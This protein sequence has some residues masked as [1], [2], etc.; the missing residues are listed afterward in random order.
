MSPLKL[1]HAAE[2]ARRT[3]G[4]AK[5]PYFWRAL[6]QLADD[7]GFKR[8]VQEALPSFS[9]FGQMDRRR[10]LQLLGASLAFGGL[11]A[12]SGPPPEQIVPWVMQPPDATPD[13]PKF[14]A[15]TLAYAGD[16]IGVLVES[17][18][19]RPTKIEGNPLHPDS[20]GATGPLPQAAVLEVWDPDRSQTP[21]HRGAKSTWEAFTAEVTAWPASYAHDAS[22]LHVLSDRIVSPT[23]RAQR[24]RWLARFPGSRWHEYAPVSQDNAD[25]GAAL[26]FGKMV[27]PRYHFDQADVI[28][29]LEAEFLDVMPGRVAYARAFAER[30]KAEHAAQTMN[31]LYVVEATPSL[32]GTMADHRWML[33]SSSVALFALELAHALDIDPGTTPAAPSGITAKRLQALRSDLLAHRGRS[34]ILAGESQ[35]PEVHALVH[36]LNEK[37]GNTGHTVDYLTLPDDAGKRYSIE[38]L[39][40]AIR[41]G[42]VQQLVVLDCNAAYAAPADLNF[43][44]LL[45]RVPKLVHWGLYVDETAHLADW[46]VPASHAL[47]SWSD[48]QTRAGV[49]SIVQPLIEPLYGGRS[50]H[51]FLALL[52][53]EEVQDG[54][55]IV[56]G[57]WRTQHPSV[58]WPDSVRAGLVS[59]IA[60]SIADVRVRQG[61]LSG[62]SPALPSAAVLELIFRPDATVW[63]GRYANNGWLQELSKW[64]SQLTWSNAAFVSPQLAREQDLSHGDVVLLRSH[65]R[66]V[67]APVWITPGQAPRSVTIHLGYGRKR[68]GRVGDNLGFNAYLLR[69]S[70]QPWRAEGLSLQKTGRSIKLASTQEHFEME[71]RD[72]IRRVTLAELIADPHAAEKGDKTPVSLYPE[73]AQGE[74]AWGMT[75]DLNVCIGCKGCTIACQAENNIPVVGVDQV[76]REREMHWIRVD[77]YYTGPADNPATYHQPVPCMHCEHAPCELVCPVGAT[78]HDEEGLNVQIYNRCIGTRWCSNN[79]PYKVRRFNFLQFNDLT[80]ETL[81]AQRNPEVTVRSRGVMEKCTYCI[82][83]IEIAHITAD[84]EQRR[85]KD[86]EVVTAC[87]AACPTQ[88]I[89]FGDISDKQSAVSRVKASSRNYELLEEL[90]TRPRTS[91]LAHVRNPHP[92]L[93]DET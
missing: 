86:G 23:L 11:A 64:H 32:T 71:G 80:S 4:D 82:Q 28:V 18:L 88:A 74:Y 49:M 21:L 63:D 27:A 38:D 91:Y 90:N 68:A 67:E 22:G 62:W 10:F 8:E 59:G 53:G 66:Q 46:H 51:E 83:R 76:L 93:Q 52:M 65:G 26:A 87:Q 7:A 17:H 77:R 73:N 75:V 37:L 50:I 15:T 43:S 9:S 29:S 25:R 34:L 60:P 3:L 42:Q 6:E 20:L 36:L 33:P 72:L 57:Y 81:K 45:K 30:R 70:A 19:G 58:S 69:T 1:E 85:I 48:A 56:Q 41:A 61:M 5:G 89:T 40:T 78:V 35:P 54:L 12:C 14:Y 84:R 24:D 31:R 47:E 55:A 79:C 92:G 39:A 13:I 16:V 44:D 2:L